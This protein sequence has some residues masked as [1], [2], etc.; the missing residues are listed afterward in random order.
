MVEHW[1]GPAAAEL[2]PSGTAQKTRNRKSAAQGWAFQ[3]RQTEERR[4]G[5]TVTPQVRDLDSFSK[6]LAAA[7]FLPIVIN[8][9]ACG[10]ARWEIAPRPSA[11]RKAT[12]DHVGGHTMARTSIV[13]ALINTSPDVID[14]LR[15]ALEP[16]G[17]VTVS[18]MTYDIR[19]GRTDLEGFL[20]QHDPAVVIYDIAPPYDANWRFFQHAC[21]AQSMRDRQIVLTS[22]NAEQVQK[23]IGRNE[24]VYEVVG[25]PFDLDQIVQAVKEAAHARPV[26]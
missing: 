9:S 2:M 13:A 20:R 17:I 15:R 1:H 7:S 16:A 18:A 3:R 14:V 6:R 26:R 5:V 4:S 11:Y 12:S 19:E 23:L 21:E 10:R 25:K 8:Q 24:H 22:V